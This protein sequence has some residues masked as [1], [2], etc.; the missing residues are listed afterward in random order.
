MNKTLK[1]YSTFDYIVYNFME[2]VVYTLASSGKQ[3]S[4]WAVRLSRL[5]NAHSRPLFSGRFDP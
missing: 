1:S 3:A 4:K 2:I 5:E